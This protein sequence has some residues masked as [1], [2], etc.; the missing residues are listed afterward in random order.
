MSSIVLA[1]FLPPLDIVDSLI[2][3]EDWKAG[4]IGRTTANTSNHYGI[5]HAMGS[6]SDSAIEHR[7]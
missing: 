4:I 7:L 2:W 1:L 3:D 6:T 5:L